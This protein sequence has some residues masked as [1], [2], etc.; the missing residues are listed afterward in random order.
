M[1]LDISTLNRYHI[2]L[3]WIPEGLCL[4]W[5]H[6][7]ILYVLRQAL[8]PRVNTPDVSE[9]CLGTAEARDIRVLHDLHRF[10][11]PRHQTW[12][13]G[14]QLTHNCRYSC[15]QAT[16]D[17]TELCSFFW[18]VQCILV[19]RIE[20]CKD[21][22]TPQRQSMK[23]TT[24]SL[25]ETRKQRERR[26][27]YATEAYHP[28]CT[29][30]STMARQLYC[31]QRRLG[32]MIWMR[33]LPEIMKC[34]QQTIGYCPRSLNDVGAAYDTFHEDCV[35]FVPAKL[36]LPL[37][38]SISFIVRTDHE[39]PKWI[40]N[41]ADTTG[42]FYDGAFCCLKCSSTL[43][44]GLELSI[45]PPIRFQDKV[46]RWRTIGHS[47]MHCRLCW[48]SLHWKRKKKYVSESHTSLRTTMIMDSILS[49]W[50]Y[51]L[52][53]SLWHLRQRWIQPPP[54][55]SNLMA[56][57]TK[58]PVPRQASATIWVLSSCYS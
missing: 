55:L 44:I 49:L 34:T 29:R 51:P 13:H 56:R 4:S 45:K 24:C 43:V 3:G 16:S 21:C 33:N 9:P 40:Q 50:D 28:T 26:V 6:C 25:D 8:R 7:H 42:E 11:L 14:S 57:H 20:S 38:E 10:P 19:V 53:V 52:F 18:L 23:W 1:F 37:L 54:V 32:Q 58:Q 30:P 47:M 46:A 22:S 39:A 41:I 5:W 17:S 15:L 2:I 48:L 31:G 12:T 27:A 36:L 35:T